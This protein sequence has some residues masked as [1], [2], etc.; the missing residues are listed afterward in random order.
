[1][2]ESICDARNK[3]IAK[4]RAVTWAERP[5]EKNSDVQHQMKKVKMEGMQLQVEKHQ[6]KRITDQ[7]NL[8][9]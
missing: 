3:D 4:E 6:V 7:I 9:E 8:L 5:V 1:M 2:H